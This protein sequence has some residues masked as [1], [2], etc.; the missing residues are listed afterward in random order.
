MHRSTPPSQNFGK[1]GQSN[2]N[3]PVSTERKQKKIKRTVK[4]IKEKISNIKEK[5]SFCFRLRLV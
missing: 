4:E 2:H 3:G 5:V 1:T